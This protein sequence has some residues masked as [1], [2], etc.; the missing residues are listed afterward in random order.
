MS[1][2][3]KPGDP[4]V[5]RSHPGAQA[6]DGVVTSL[7]NDGRTVFVRY[8]GQHPDAPGKGT[9]AADLAH[10]HKGAA[11]DRPA[12]EPPME[13]VEVV[14]RYGGHRHLARARIGNLRIRDRWTTLCRG[15]SAWTLESWERSP[16][17]PL[18]LSVDDMRAL[19]PCDACLV[20]KLADSGGR[21]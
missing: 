21:S 12:P 5:Y 19:P 7:S 16:D 17:H 8:R 3:F 14:T 13:Y 6:E 20:G 18:E 10:A 11:P 1:H 4:V 2:D 9:Y 15:T